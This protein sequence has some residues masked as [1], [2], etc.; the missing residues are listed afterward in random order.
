MPVSPKMI[1]P[2]NYLL[3]FSDYLK[4]HNNYYYR[5]KIDEDKPES[6]DDTSKQDSE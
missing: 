3:E 5:G 1:I 2:D 6:T 4:D